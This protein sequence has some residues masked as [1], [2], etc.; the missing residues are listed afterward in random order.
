MDKNVYNTTGRTLTFF[1]IKLNPHSTTLIRESQ[2]TSNV[3]KRLEIY[4]KMGDIRIFDYEEPEPVPINEPIKIEV[5][6]KKVEVEKSVEQSKPTIEEIALT[7]TTEEETKKVQSK[8]QKVKTVQQTK[9]KQQR[10]KTKQK[11][12]TKNA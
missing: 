10:S 11:E 4:R 9:K 6:E 1:N 3:K 2:L 12:E 7:D 8:P 5:E